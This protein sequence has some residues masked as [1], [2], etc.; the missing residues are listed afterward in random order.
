MNALD[1]KLLLFYL[2]L[3]P[4]QREVAQLTSQGLSNCEIAEA[5]CI[6]PSVVAGHLTNIYSE[7]ATTDLPQASQSKR[8]AVIR[9]LSGF[10]ERNP[11]LQVW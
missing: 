7:L 3:T 8:Y 4:R 5:M 11:D 1:R 2:R 10:F 9:L 6:A